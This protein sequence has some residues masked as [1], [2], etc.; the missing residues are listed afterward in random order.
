MSH[1]GL[2]FDFDG[3]LVKTMEDHFYAWNKTFSEFSVTIHAEE[4]FPIEG[5]SVKKMAE[6]FMRKVPNIKY[7]LD[8]ILKI[9]DD[10]FRAI[11]RFTPYDGVEPLILR[12]RKNDVPCAIVTAGLIARIRMTVPEAFLGQFNS[13]I[14]GESTTHAK[15][16][17]EP[18][19]TGAAALQL[20]PKDCIVIENA[21]LGIES[22][23]AA[24]CTC[25]AVCS[26][27]SADKFSHADYVVQNFSDLEK[28]PIIQNLL[29]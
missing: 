25:I 7:S 1:K 17:P 21:P 6:S 29:S 12:A 19:L 18:Y 28:L 5:S 11:H 22:G 13:L 2:L 9:K 23:K 27:V 14:T 8:E 26:T 15:P 10:H 16:H 4:F 24:G 3:T 20:N